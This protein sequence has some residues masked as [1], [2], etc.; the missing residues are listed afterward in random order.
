MYSFIPSKKFFYLQ[1]EPITTDNLQTYLK[2]DK[3]SA[4]HGNVAFANQT[5]KGLFFY[6]K[7]ADH[8]AHPSGIIRLVSN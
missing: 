1:D 5:G 2:K 8:K 7:N 6:A 4:A 3:S